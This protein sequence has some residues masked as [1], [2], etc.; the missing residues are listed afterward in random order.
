MVKFEEAM[1]RNY[2]RKYICKKCKTVIR[3]DPLKV[4]VVKVKCRK[5]GFSKLRSPR[6]K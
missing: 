5:C 4:V 3:A 1:N 2:G 6:K